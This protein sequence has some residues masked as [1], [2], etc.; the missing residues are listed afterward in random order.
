MNSLFRCFRS[1]GV[2]LEHVLWP[3]SPALIA[4]LLAPAVA[5]AGSGEFLYLENTDSGDIS[6]ISIPGH[7]VVST[8][9]VGTFLDDVSVSSDGRVLYVNRVP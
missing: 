3:V 5:A 4:V 7:E 6:V 9:K 8:I 1:L 2:T